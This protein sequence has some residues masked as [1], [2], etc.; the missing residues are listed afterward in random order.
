MANNIH[1]CAS[2]A[3]ARPAAPEWVVKAERTVYET[4]KVANTRD[5]SDANKADLYRQRHEEVQRQY[6]AVVR[7]ERKRKLSDA[8]TAA[9]TIVSESAQLKARIGLLE[10]ENVRLRA[11]DSNSADGAGSLRRDVYDLRREN[12]NL[13]AEIVRK[14]ARIRALEAKCDRVSEHAAEIAR[15]PPDVVY[16]PGV[17]P[18]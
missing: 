4:W 5:W 12:T 17:G 8:Q 16:S 13:V 7:K 14:G 11:L 6:Q 15:Q 9:D 3:D 1:F 18:L 10:A 2:M